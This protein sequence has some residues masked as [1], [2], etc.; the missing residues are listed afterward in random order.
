M[1]LEDDDDV[2]VAVDVSF[3]QQLVVNDMF[4]STV[5]VIVVTSVMDAWMV[6]ALLLS[7]S[8]LDRL[9]LFLFGSNK[10]SGGSFFH[11]TS[12]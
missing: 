9:F 2:V 6:V 12:A 5:G 4:Q 8:D 1:D 3:V 10:C 11:C 7:T